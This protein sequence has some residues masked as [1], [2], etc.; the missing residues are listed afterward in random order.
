M[1]LLKDLS[2]KKCPMRPPEFHGLVV[3]PPAK[4]SWISGAPACR[5]HVGLLGKNIYGHK[6]K[7]IQESSYFEV[8]N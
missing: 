5:A 3:Y 7:D 8:S 6:L 4:L 1:R 2:G